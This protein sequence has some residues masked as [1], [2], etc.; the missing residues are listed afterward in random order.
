MED[1]LGIRYRKNPKKRAMIEGFDCAYDPV[2]PLLL[3]TQAV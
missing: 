1:V 2:R 3:M